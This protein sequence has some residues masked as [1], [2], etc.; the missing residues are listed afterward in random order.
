[1]A[2]GLTRAVM[3]T[4]LVSH[5]LIFKAAREIRLCWYDEN[6]ALPTFLLHSGVY[7]SIRKWF[8]FPPLSEN[9]I[10][11][12]SRDTSFFDSHHGLFALHLAYF[13]FILPFYFPFL[14]FSFPFLPFSFTFSPFSFSPFHIFSPKWHRLIFP[15]PGGYFPKYRPL[16]TFKATPT[17]TGKRGMRHTSTALYFYGA[18]STQA[19]GPF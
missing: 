8:L 19:Q 12:P 17:A 15:P 1:M 3:G 13:A 5:F 11:S 6:P 10:F 2:A 7:I 18:K 9:D 4:R 14:S 16:I